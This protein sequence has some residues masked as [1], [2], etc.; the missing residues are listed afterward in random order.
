M[1]PRT[2]PD[3]TRFW[4]ASHREYSG[5]RMEHGAVPRSMQTARPPA[6]AGASSGRTS[7]HPVRRG[8]RPTR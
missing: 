2:G 8:Q 1:R 7:G 5:H 6:C 3:Q 4:G